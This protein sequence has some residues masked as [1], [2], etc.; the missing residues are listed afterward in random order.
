[1]AQKQIVIGTKAQANAVLV[2]SL[3]QPVNGRTL[4]KGR[5]DLGKYR[6]SLVGRSCEVPEHVQALWTERR[7]DSDG[8]YYAL[9]GVFAR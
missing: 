4:E 6:N 1:M 7:K 5:W 3:F 8:V 2:N 9:F